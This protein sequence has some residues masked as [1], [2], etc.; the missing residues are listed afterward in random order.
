MLHLALHVPRVMERAGVTGNV[1]GKIR[2]ACL[3]VSAVEAI[4]QHLVLNVPR[5]TVGVW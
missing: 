4:V 2:D 5:L 3:K 1:Y